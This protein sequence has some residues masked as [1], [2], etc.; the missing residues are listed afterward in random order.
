VTVT[1]LRPAALP[2][3]EGLRGRLLLDPIH[4]V[5]LE[6]VVLVRGDRLHA[7]VDHLLG[8][9]LHPVDEPGAGGAAPDAPHAPSAAEAPE[10]G[11]AELNH[12]AVTATAAVELVEQRSAESHP[13]S[14]HP[15]PESSKP[16][17]ERMRVPV[18][19]HA[20]APILPAEAAKHP[21]SGE[22]IQEILERIRAPEKL[23]EDVLR[24]SEHEGGEPEGVFEAVAVP[25]S[26]PVS[27]ATTTVVLVVV[28][29]SLLAV[30]VVH[31][32]LLLVRENLVGF[33]NLFELF[34]GLVLTFDV[35][36]RMPPQS[37]L[38]V[39][40]LNVGL[41]GVLRNVQYTV[42]VNHCFDTYLLTR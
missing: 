39:G 32:S 2:P 38:A 30:L 29:Q 4:R 16:A 15:E 21:E 24:I 37:Q 8:R 20:P 5:A 3:P 9:D 28:R 41:A 1:R 19:H 10:R 34:R 13:E 25:V 11:A 35:L 42:I 7:V 31:F 18:S 27:P 6:D 33:G 17:G 14:R 36:V 22:R 12:A 23:P 26:M 40:F